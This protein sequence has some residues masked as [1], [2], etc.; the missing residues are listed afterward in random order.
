MASDTG[1]TN[2]QFEKA[3]FGGPQA[4]SLSCAAC[5]KSID[6]FYF[7]VNGRTFCM[8]CK[9]K[10]EAQFKGGSKAL[11][12]LKAFFAGGLAALLG[13]GIYYGIE[14]ATGYE[15]GLVAII[16]GFGVGL[17][18]RWGS[19]NRGGW[20]YQLLAMFLTYNA[21]VLTYVPAALGQIKDDL[22]AKA[23][24]QAPLG[25]PQAQATPNDSSA[26]VS[27]ASGATPGVADTTLAA[28]ANPTPADASATPAALPAAA[29]T[30]GANMDFGKIIL[31]LGALLALAYALPFLAGFQNILGLVILAIGLY[32]AWKINKG[33]RIVINGPFR[34]GPPK[35]P[36]PPPMQ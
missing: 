28:P 19:E 36:P 20:P 13:F 9:R 33:R 21:I 32:E 8:E 4:P 1:P 16:V 35:D 25:Q 34:A 3:D 23:V 11:R 30:Q 22:K 5:K 29:P 7:E 10:I 6:E 24:S 17:A 15:F 2:L 27:A 18:V 26:P 14:K 12:F 31:G